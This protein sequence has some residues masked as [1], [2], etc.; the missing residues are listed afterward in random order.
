MACYSNACK[1]C[2]TKVVMGISVLIFILGL[3]CIGFGAMQM[4]VVSEATDY[5]DFTVDQSSLGLGVLVLGV[6]SVV[7]GLLG[8]CTGKYKKPY[9]ACPFILLT[10]IVGL[11][12]LI[13]GFIMMGGAAVI[14][15][16]VDSACVNAND[17]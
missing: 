3:V 16:A 12:T 17:L 10:M 9:F 11:V 13:I 14:Q 1:N 6:L 2:C 4:G 8:C 15:T 5:V 7:I